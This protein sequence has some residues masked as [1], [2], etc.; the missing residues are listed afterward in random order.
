MSEQ[1][2]QEGDVG[3]D[4]ADTELHERAEHLAAGN[5]VCGATDRALDE[6]RV[7]VR[8]DLRASETGAG[9]ETHA[10]TASAAV[11]LNLSG[12]GLEA[13]SGIFSG[14]T[15]LDGESALGDV[16]LGETELGKS[17]TS[18]DLDLSGDNVD[19]SDLL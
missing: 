8:R 13:L 12:V 15:A 19:A 7:V 11:D 5:L 18:G 3:L 6:E 10:V 17:S 1:T 2:E 16:V 14:D 9:I 4:T